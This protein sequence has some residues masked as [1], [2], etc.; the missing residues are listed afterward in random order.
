LNTEKGWEEKLIEEVGVLC[1]LYPKTFF[2]PGSERPLEINIRRKLFREEER[3]KHSL[4]KSRLIRVLKFYTR[5]MGYLQ[6]FE[7]NTCRI[8]LDGSE[9]EL[10]VDH[11]ENAVVHKKKLE[12]FLIKL[13]EKKKKQVADVKLV[14]LKVEQEKVVTEKTKVKIKK[15][16]VKIEVKKRVVKVSVKKRRV[17]PAG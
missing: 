6:S 11:I 2:R 14:E 13:A 4:S 5:S 1:N 3:K 10:V 12:K 9:T 16:K 15:N 17:I 7:T 8:G